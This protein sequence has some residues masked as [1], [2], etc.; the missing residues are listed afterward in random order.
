MGRHERELVAR[1]VEMTEVARQLRL[2]RRLANLTYD[3]LAQT[4]CLSN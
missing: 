1:A 3:Q 2:M 4:T